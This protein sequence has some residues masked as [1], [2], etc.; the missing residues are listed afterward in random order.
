MNVGK[1]KAL[2]MPVKLKTIAAL[3]PCSVCVKRV[4]ANS[5]Q[6]RVHR[7]C[8]GLR[9]NIVKFTEVVQRFSCAAFHATLSRTEDFGELKKNSHI[10]AST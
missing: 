2:S 8:S 3:D 6:K 4:G 1:T 7:R 9:E 5:M 10:L